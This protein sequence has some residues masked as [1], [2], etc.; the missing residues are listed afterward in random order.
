MNENQKTI[1]QLR[2]LREDM[3]S[4]RI[5]LNKLESSIDEPNI[6]ELEYDKEIRM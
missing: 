5:K 4:L 3:D 6:E 2:Q 1:E